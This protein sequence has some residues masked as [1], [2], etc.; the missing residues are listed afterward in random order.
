MLVWGSPHTLTLN[1][2]HPYVALK[3]Y[4]Y[5]YTCTYTYMRI[6]VYIPTKSICGIQGF[7]LV[8]SAR[9]EPTPTVRK[10]FVTKPLS[11]TCC[12]EIQRTYVDGDGFRVWGLEFRA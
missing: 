5:T 12:T 6:Y 3:I 4:I 10:G 2:M 9:N 7:S 11:P 1:P 8:A